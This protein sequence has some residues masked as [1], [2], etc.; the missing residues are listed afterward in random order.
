MLIENLN[1]LHSLLPKSFSDEVKSEELTKSTLLATLTEI[2]QNLQKE[3]FAQQFIK[4]ITNDCRME[5]ASFEPSSQEQPEINFTC[6]NS[7]DFARG[8]AQSGRTVVIM[9]AANA[10]RPGAG[11][12]EK[13]TFQEALT[14][15]SDLYLKMLVDFR[16]V[17]QDLVNQKK[18]FCDINP[19]DSNIPVWQ[20]QARFLK[21]IIH[22]VIESIKN[23]NVIANPNF[24]NDFLQYADA[25]YGDMQN[26]V[27]E[28][29]TGFVKNCRLLTV[30]LKNTQDLFVNESVNLELIERQTPRVTIIEVA[31]PDRRK[32]ER[33]YDR[34]STTLS[35]I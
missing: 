1:T 25:I 30:S 35:R 15:H 17:L 23:E 20:F 7:I 24:I 29:D 21:L 26:K 27:F 28:I 19:E 31:A 3:S 13:G 14:R 18:N 32:T 6:G 4:L 34:G 12:Y 22:F 10:Q 8:Q 5:L 16:K 9:D 11:A 2:E 33:N